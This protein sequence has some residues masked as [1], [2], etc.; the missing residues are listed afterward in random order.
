MQP[1]KI[2][3][4]LVGR[5]FKKKVHKQKRGYMAPHIHS[6]HFNWL[7]TREHQAHTEVP[8]KTLHI[9]SSVLIAMVRNRKNVDKS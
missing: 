4:L 8:L 2:G 7:R 5:V 9:G 1:T 6:V 3:F